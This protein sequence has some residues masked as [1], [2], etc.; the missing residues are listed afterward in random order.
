MPGDGP[1]PV[2]GVVSCG[3]GHVLPPTRRR[4]L[5][6]NAGRGAIRALASLAAAAGLAAVGP[7][8]GA[9][10][11][12]AV[13]AAAPTAA[14]AASSSAPEATTTASNR[15]SPLLVLQSQST[16]VTP[17]SST[18]TLDLSL[19][20]GTPAP[21][22]AS[23]SVAVY[24]CLSTVSA[25]DQ[26]ATSSS[27]SGTP[28]F[29]TSTPWPATGGT[30]AL[31]FPVTASRPTSGAANTIDLQRSSSEC[32]GNEGVYPVRVQLQNASGSVL[33]GFTTDLVYTDAPASTN[34]VHLATVVP[35]SVPLHSAPSVTAGTLRRDPLAALTGLSNTTVNQVN[36][37]IGVL[38]HADQAVTVA[39]SPQLF[40]ALG[41]R[42]DQTAVAGL[43]RLATSSLDQLTVSPYVPVNASSLVR[44]GLGDEL[45]AQVTRGKQVLAP[46]TTRTGT[47]ATGGTG[48]A[49]GVPTSVGAAGVWVTNDGVDDQTV[50]QLEA[51]GYDELVIPPSAVASQPTTGDSGGTL[52]SSVE[53]FTVT[54]SRGAAVT[55]V[56]SNSDLSSWFTADPGNPV[57]AA[58][59]LLA[60]LAQIYY[61]QP[62]DHHQRSVVA[63]APNGW[64]PDPAF[65]STLLKGL[66]GNPI[67]QGT[68]LADLFAS[69]PSPTT[70]RSG[71]CRLSGTSGAGGR[72]PAATIKQER[73]RITGY[74][75]AVT[76]PVTGREL[77]DKLGDLLL[78]SQSELLR[79]GQRTTVL[80]DVARSLSAQM[81]QFAVSGDKTITLTSRSAPV[82]I[83]I[84]SSAPYS[85]TGTLTLTSDKLQFAN[86]KGQLSETRVLAPAGPGGSH[87][88]VIYVGMKARASGEFSVDISFQSPASALVIAN[89]TLNVRSTATSII[90]VVLS[91]GAVAVL[92]LWWVRTT[93]RRRAKARARRSGADGEPAGEPELAGSDHGD[94]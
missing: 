18:F 14:A 3:A 25:F 40:Q 46:L 13:S 16:W 74:V 92:L 75:A 27:P 59:Q 20:A 55:A 26:D 48:T 49:T 63:V 36:N 52:G 44:S 58:N 71:S 51:S 11:A 42:N 4:A 77:G 22:K 33:D 70:C 76:Q 78:S 83:D 88:N 72:L 54:T 61:E 57:L 28:F 30:A 53:P 38:E 35:V 60:E 69:Y 50:T 31:A 84:Q 93:L 89:G 8:L 64:Q 37:L 41:N 5:T 81:S 82:P 10:P 21:S 66:D 2:V 34:K 62:N 12:G 65:V 6:H 73:A 67:A 1:A 86:G 43:N 17:A 45:A 19:A 39:L 9:A 80:H 91:L 56:T 79:R 90:G 32:S 15:S 24:S 29:H 87:D 85:I 47:S 68:T 23:V 94:R 7:G